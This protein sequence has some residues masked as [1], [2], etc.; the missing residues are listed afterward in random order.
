MKHGGVPGMTLK[1]VA[2]ELGCSVEHLMR[3]YPTKEALLLDLLDE[4]HSRLDIPQYAGSPRDHLYL[5]FLSLREHLKEYPWVLEVAEEG[6]IYGSRLMY[7]VEETL[8]TFGRAG[9]HGMP[10]YLAYRTLWFHL[11][12]YEYFRIDLDD[13][14]KRIQR[15]IALRIDFEDVPLL[16]QLFPQI[17]RLEED[18]PYH[19]ALDMMLDSLLSQPW[20]KY[21]DVGGED[22][23]E[24]AA[25]AQ[26]LSLPTPLRRAAS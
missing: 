12:G 23:A 3:Y 8:V 11:L 24:I 22:A 10:A 19:V 21:D 6:K 5:M 4:V 16:S 18:C 26:D 2:V 14:T 25:I 20:R 15:D 9:I 1:R 13:R 17:A 7:F